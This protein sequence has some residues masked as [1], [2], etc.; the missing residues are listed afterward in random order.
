MCVLNQLGPPFQT[1]PNQLAQAEP[2]MRWATVKQP[3]NTDEQKQ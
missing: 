3:A 2:G 1:D